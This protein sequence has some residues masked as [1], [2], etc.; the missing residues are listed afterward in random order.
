MFHIAQVIYFPMVPKW[1]GDLFFF[2]MVKGLSLSEQIAPEVKQ[3]VLSSF[4][5]YGHSG[6]VESARELFMQIDGLP[7]CKDDFSSEDTGLLSSLLRAGSECHGYN[8]RIVGHSLGGAVAVLLGMRLYNRYPNLHVYTYGAL[9]CVNF[10]IAEACS[11]FV[12][13]IVYCDE[14]SARLSVSSILRLRAAAIASLSQDTS[15]NSAMVCKLA[16][17]IFNVN[18]Y[19]E[20]REN[21]RIH[22]PSIQTSAATDDD[23][24]LMHWRRHYKQAIKGVSGPGHQPLTHQTVTSFTDYPDSG[25]LRDGFEGYNHGNT[26]NSYHDFGNFENCD[27]LSTR[28]QPFFE[29]G[30]DGVSTEPISQIVDGISSSVE[31]S[32][33]E[34]PEMYLPGFIIHILPEQTRSLVTLW[35]SWKIHDREHNFKAYVVNRENFKDIIVSPYMFLDHLPWRVHYAMRRVL[36]TSKAQNQIDGSL[37][38]NSGK[39]KFMGSPLVL[40]T[41]RGKQEKDGT[42]LSFE[43]WSFKALELLIGWQRFELVWVFKS[44]GAAWTRISQVRSTSSLLYSDQVIP[45]SFHDVEGMDFVAGKVAEVGAQHFGYI[46]DL[47]RN[48]EQLNEKATTLY[49]KKEDM[50]F[51]INRDRIRKR[52]KSEC[53]DWLR[54][55]EEV[56]NKVDAFKEEY[57]QEAE[58]ETWWCPDIQSHLKLGRHIVE[59]TNQISKL[60]EESTK[61]EGAVVVD[62]LPQTVEAKPVLTIEE[63]TSTERTLQRILNNVRDPR[64]HKIV[65]QRYRQLSSKDSNKALDLLFVMTVW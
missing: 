62:V 16:W 65:Q 9:P 21:G 18:K 14:F 19:H 1:H 5:H 26:M 23:N 35:K 2:V 52:P 31:V 47:K 49:S 41:Q 17:R 3:S 53:Q 57:S 33:E 4:P 61:F 13:S 55:V 56:H 8:V 24:S 37:R 28:I 63:G 60:I 45:K 22:T 48:F 39:I 54:R 50:E 34:H 51:E 42:L 11:S 10:V 20:S 36:E 64:K 44:L 38:V 46:K 6:I 25:I 58:S 30:A 15:A 7:A 32:N 29:A 12:T 40:P 59:I 27:T 43:I